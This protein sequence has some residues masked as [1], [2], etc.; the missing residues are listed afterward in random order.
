MSNLISKY[1]DE[2]IA[3]A[4]YIGTPG[5]GILAADESTGTIGKRLAGINVENVETN[6]RTLRELLFTAPDVLQYLSGVIL[7]EETLYQSTAAGKPFV[8]VLK[9]GGVLPG[10]KVDKGTVE[11]A[12]TDQE[13]T[14]QG[15]DGLAQRCQKYYEAGARFAKW[16]SVLKIGPNEPSELAIHEN[17][18]GLARYAVICQENGLVP[19]VEPEIL[20]DG[21]HDINKCAAVTERVLAAVYKAL[22][23]HHV[24]LEGTL[25]K[26]NMVT[27]GSDSAKVAPSVVAEHTVRALQRTVPAAV[28]AVVF[29]SGGQSEE[30]ATLNLNA[31][32]QVKGKKPWTL[33]FSF[34]RALQQST[35]KAWSGKE[36]NIKK[37]QDALLTRA[38]GNSEA[39]LGTYKGSAQLGDGAS[40]S[41]H[42]KD[43]KY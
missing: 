28:P 10:I 29:L 13:T 3:N 7:F 41:L 32:N 26:P 2:L 5:K 38:K 33:S 25:L 6:R 4:A 14:T 42:V 18:Y 24:L 16:R 17:A 40:E 30:E 43:Y 27:P 11:L 20:V 31:I 23:D 39:T 36:E 19:I 21:P 34:G 12:G 35:L 22:S 1:H 8:E 15:L 9:E 37:A